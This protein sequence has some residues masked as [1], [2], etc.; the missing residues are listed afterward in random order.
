MDADKNFGAGGGLDGCGRRHRAICVHLRSSAA[1]YSCLGRQHPG[2]HPP[3]AQAP[4]Q[5]G[6]PKPATVHAY[7][8][9]RPRPPAGPGQTPAL[10]H[11]T[12]QSRRYALQ[13]EAVRI[14]PHRTAR[15]EPEPQ[16]RRI[17]NQ[18][19][20]TRTRSAALRVLRRTGEPRPNKARGQTP[21]TT[22]PA[23]PAPAH[24]PRSNPMQPS[25]ATS[26]QPNH[27]PD[28][29]PAHATQP[30]PPAAPQPPH[31]WQSAPPG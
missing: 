11:R 2:P 21:T 7:Q 14:S 18:T 8:R 13:P 28:R 17:P 19:P 30:H 15:R 25:S 26:R 4:S 1:K 20:S 3:K 27:D 23:R 5:P 22:A 10:D 9:T 31:P 24:P 29:Q 12:H 16:N 6:P